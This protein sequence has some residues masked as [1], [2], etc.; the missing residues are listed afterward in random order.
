M[1]N[2][3]EYFLT[4]S[5]RWQ[6]VVSIQVW[7][8]GLGHFFVAFFSWKKW[9]GGTSPPPICRKFPENVIFIFEP[10][11]N[12]AKSFD[13][14]WPWLYNRF[15][16][17]TFIKS[18]PSPKARKIINKQH[19]HHYQLFGK[20]LIAEISKNIWNEI[21]SGILLRYFYLDTGCLDWDIF[22]ILLWRQ[23]LFFL[24]TTWAHRSHY[25]PSWSLQSTQES[26]IRTQEYSGAYEY[27]WVLLK[28]C[29]RFII[30]A[31]D[32]SWVYLAPWHHAHE[33]SWP[34]WLLL[35]LMASNDC[36][37]F[38]IITHECSWAVMS[39]YEHSW[40]WCHRA[41]SIYEHS[42]AIMITHE[43]G[44]TNTHKSH[45]TMAP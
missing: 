24:S 41:I 28:P 27:L 7:C 9:M 4:P 32:W 44:V 25:K 14:Q 8:Q 20:S 13:L 17:E 40:A 10:F 11:P 3:S 43:N 39:S 31:Y 37:W 38:P 6:H 45:G 33:C 12:T 16:L 22:K 21:V 30:R 5:L 35:A 1:G 42:L 18:S 29:A 36:S 2:S 23:C 34:M 26:L 19:L 15:F